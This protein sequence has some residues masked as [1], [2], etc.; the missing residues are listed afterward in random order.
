[1]L[2][3]SNIPAKLIIVLIFLGISLCLFFIKVEERLYY[4][5][6]VFLRYLFS[7]KSFNGAEQVAVSK[8]ED[9][10]IHFKGGY[11][12]GVLKITPLEFFLL[13]EE[14][15]DNL[16]DVF[17][18]IYKNLAVGQKISVVKLDRPV[19]LDDY[20]E[21]VKNTKEKLE[22][23]ADKFSAKMKNAKRLILDNRIEELEKIN[24]VDN[25]CYYNAFYIVLYGSKESVN[26][27]LF[28]DQRELETVGIKTTRIAGKELMAFVKR[29]F[30]QV[31]EEREITEE[32]K[33]EDVLPKSVIHSSK[34]KCGEVYDG[35]FC[36]KCGTGEKIKTEKENTNIAKEKKT[37]ADIVNII[38]P[39]LITV[40]SF[41]LL[42]CSL[43]IGLKV[44][45]KGI[46]DKL[47]FITLLRD[48]KD[49]TEMIQGVGK[50]PLVM[51]LIA[52]IVNIIISLASF[53]VSITLLC[54]SFAKKTNKKLTVWAVM[55]IVSTIVVISM[56]V[57]L[58]SVSNTILKA[59]LVKLSGG[60]ICAIVFIMAIS[61]IGIILKRIADPKER[62]GLAIAKL[63]VGLV[64]IVFGAV[65]IC[66]IN[67]NYVKLGENPFTAS[68]FLSFV[69]GVSDDNYL[70]AMGKNY[71]LISYFAHIVA[72]TFVAIAITSMLK[73]LFDGNNK[74][75][76]ALS[77]GI[78]SG[79]SG[80]IYWLGAMLFASDTK[81]LN[82]IAMTEKLFY[83]PSVI[84]LV[85]AVVFVLLSIAYYVISSNLKK[86]QE[87]TIYLD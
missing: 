69:L 38:N 78:C 71:L 86:Q 75:G 26:K 25:C 53:I 55:P 65:L 58:Y 34:Y 66:V 82:A 80:I 36:P 87:N 4:E 23:S 49:L 1:V 5:L 21:D 11:C 22:N 9:N 48:W 59:D 76:T 72:V 73:S 12:A 61:I 3:F 40:L 79:A 24:K 33:L 17:S 70:G 31:F 81:V 47:T 39:C 41:V 57:N 28:A 20:I 42:I 27:T 18:V 50:L 10:I 54:M 46:E 35:N 15:Q 29:S 52:N 74:K 14:M 43:L 84:V 64:S 60:S 67:M 83:T 56:C 32:T 51:L 68:M 6:F 16:I 45:V 44:E 63:V 13:R 37:F 19:F 85:L 8:I 30:T 7:K 77:F 2:G 62:T